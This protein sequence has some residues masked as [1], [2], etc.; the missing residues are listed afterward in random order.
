MYNGNTLSLT[1]HSNGFAEIQFNNQAESINKFDQKTIDELYDAINALLNAKDV[2]GLLFT[3]AKPVFVAGADIT[4]FTTMF[5]ATK[6]EFFASV[7]H[8]NQLFSQIEDLPFPSVAAI[9]GHA[10]GGGLE[11]CLACDGRII[12][13]KA[14]IGLPETSLGIMPGWGGTVRLPRLTNYL[15]AAQWITTGAQYRSDV[16][17]EAGVVH[18]VV[19]P[20]QLHSKAIQL[21][22]EMA[23]GDRD[24]RAERSRKMS[25]LPQTQAELEPQADHLRAAVIGKVGHHY[26]APLKALETMSAAAGLDRDQAIGLETQTFYELSQTSQARA[27][28]GLFLGD[29]YIAKRAKHYSHALGEELPPVSTAGVI[30]AGIMGGGIAYQNAIKGYPVVMKDINQ[31][32]LDLGFKEADKLLNKLVSRGKLSEQKSIEIRDRITATL[33]NGDIV[34]CDMLVEAVVEQESIKKQV[35]S[36]LENQLKPSAYICSNTSTISINR[37]ASSLQHPENFCG[38]HFFNPVHTMK[39]VEVIRGDKTSDSTIAAVCNYALGLGKK[40]I[41]V[42]DCPGFLVN[43]VLFALCFGLEMLIAQGADFQQIDIVA[44]EWGMP[45]GPAY[46]MD[47]VGIDTVNHCYSVMMNGL[48]ER[49]KK[50]V[51]VWPSEAL[52]K[53][54]RLGQK[55]ALGYYKYELNEKGRPTKMV[56]PSAVEILHDLF[57]SCYELDQQEIIDRL[58][59]AM[60]MEMV[61]CLE[62]GIVASPME[63]DMALIY[64]VGF[65]LFRGGICRWMD[66]EGLQSICD[67]ADQYAGLSELYRPTD[68]LREMA[69][70]NQTFH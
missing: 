27:L 36:E 58:M 23:D 18:A 33:D 47:V 52:F 26:P 64:G 11:I 56:D 49:F 55:N 61:H 68:K 12:S 69:A 10:L 51:D 41:V 5:S 16:A 45:M 25:P 22:Q 24:Y 53:A 6:D 43:R 54:D 31:S 67:R 8:V 32:A 34:D 48:P 60:A 38:M 59:L 21:L 15:I 37:L 14:T 30:G 57:G 29:Q 40:P 44:E 39:L 66:E 13:S 42:N 1:M 28:I 2:R 9:N 4:E 19:E 65:P 70:K 17:L 46:L 50:I 20:D 63:A 3:S 7:N 62:E 35:L